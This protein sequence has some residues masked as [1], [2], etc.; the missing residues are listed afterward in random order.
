MENKYALAIPEKLG[1]GVDFWPCI[2]GD[3]LTR[4]P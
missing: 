1:V 3:F 4:C 2:E